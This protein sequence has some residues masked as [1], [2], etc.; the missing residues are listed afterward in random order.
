MPRRPEEKP[1]G[2]RPHH[3]PSFH[4]GDDE[5]AHEAAMQAVYHDPNRD[6]SLELCRERARRR[7][8]FQLGD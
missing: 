8:N 6:F 2:R 5:E 3:L 1:R 7:I 4:E